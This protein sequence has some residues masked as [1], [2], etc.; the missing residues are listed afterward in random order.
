M[1]PS[2]EQ[3]ITLLN[4]GQMNTGIL[5]LLQQISLKKRIR[6]NSILN[7]PLPRYMKTRKYC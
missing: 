3:M 4:I 7:R 5:P 2:P 6:L 1:V